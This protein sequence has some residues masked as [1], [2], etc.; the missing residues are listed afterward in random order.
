ME[1]CE[2]RE[3]L[4]ILGNILG[5]E[6]PWYSENKE[7]I[8]LKKNL[9]GLYKEAM[10]FYKQKLA[11]SP[12]TLLYLEKRGIIKEDIQNFHL[13]FAESGVDL[14]HYLQEKWYD[15]TL[16]AGSHIFV[17]TAKKKDKFLWRRTTPME[18]RGNNQHFQS[19]NRARKYLKEIRDWADQR[20]CQSGL[21]GQSK[22]RF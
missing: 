12:D 1:N 8:Q 4:Q 15:D 21:I 9:Y 7:Q 18:I 14:Y 11:S 19:V 2:F 17:D 16:I 6:I 3:S 10:Q 13:G 22:V 20:L 5:K